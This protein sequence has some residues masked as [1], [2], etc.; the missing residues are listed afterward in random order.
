MKIIIP[1]EASIISYFVGEGNV[2]PMLSKILLRIEFF[3]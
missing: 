2:D 3:Q 1:D